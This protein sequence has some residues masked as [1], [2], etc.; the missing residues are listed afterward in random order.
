MRSGSYVVDLPDH[1]YSIVLG[2]TMLC[3][4]RPHSTCEKREGR[5]RN[6]TGTAHLFTLVSL[7]GI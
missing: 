3:S 1:R 7:G 5:Q 6:G 4:Q 2:K